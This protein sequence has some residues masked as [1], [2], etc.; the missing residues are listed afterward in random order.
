MT[1][2]AKPDHFLL[3]LKSKQKKTPHHLTQ[4]QITQ[5]SSDIVH[6]EGFLL[7][8]LQLFQLPVKVFIVYAKS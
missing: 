4:S 6:A 3:L 8:K 7:E 1:E 5:N 2:Q